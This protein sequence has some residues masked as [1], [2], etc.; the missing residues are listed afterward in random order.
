MLSH[1]R[2]ARALAEIMRL[3]DCLSYPTAIRDY[4]G[5]ALRSFLAAYVQRACGLSSDL[6]SQCTL[7]AWLTE[8]GYPTK[9]HDVKNAGRTVCF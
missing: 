6:L 1:G 5:I 4:L 9:V 3:G 2:H 7:A 8:V